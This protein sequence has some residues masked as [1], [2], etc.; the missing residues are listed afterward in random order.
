MRQGVISSEAY[1]TALIARAQAQQDLNAFITLDADHVLAA[2]RRADAWRLAGKPLGL[3]HGLPVPI[4]DS[5]NTTTCVTTNGTAALRHFQ[6]TTDALLVQRLLD[7]GAIVMGKTN[8]TELSFGWTSNN[9]TF[10]PVR[11]PFDRHRVPGGSSGGSAAAVAA[12]MAPLATAADTLGSIRV[13]ASFCGL[14]GLR[15]SFGRYPNAGAFSLTDDRLDQVG[16]LARCVDDLCLFDHAVTGQ[17]PLP[18]KGT[19]AGMRIGVAAFYESGLAAEV[20]HIYRDALSRLRAHGAVLV[21]TSLPEIV[22]R[23]FDIAATIMLHEADAG[24]RR[25][26]EDNATGLTV[27]QV[28]A[29][30]GPGIRSMIEHVAMPPHRPSRDAWLDALRQRGEL[31]AALSQYFADHAIAAMIFPATAA[32]APL[33]GEE[34]EIDIDGRRVSF[35]EAFGRNT[36]LGPAAGVPSLVL[37]AG[38]SSRNG[39]PVGIELVAPRGHDQD[40]LMLARHIEQ[41]LPAT[42]LAG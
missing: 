40:L 24:I 13:P 6:P 19:L 16:A 7:Q 22:R 30:A 37:P 27:E 33:I 35:F 5:M 28:L 42:A 9:E 25:Y 34:G 29:Q 10:G 38:M 12:G 3:L 8:L 31:Q 1:A 17:A 14:Y 2:A 11:N 36:A 26:L 32:T 15:P 4:K 21:S 18:G 20:E 39:L 23:A 41:V